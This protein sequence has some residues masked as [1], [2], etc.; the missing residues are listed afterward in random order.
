MLETFF[1]LERKLYEFQRLGMVYALNH[2]YSINGCKMGLGKTIQAIALIMRVG[3][4]ALIVCP[5][6]LRNNWKAE[7]EKFGTKCY[8]GTV[9]VVSYDEFRKGK[10]TV[11]P[12]VLIFDEAH[13]LKN[14]VTKRTKF[15]HEYVKDNPPEHLLLLTGTPIKNRV[16]EFYSLMRLCSL[17]P[18]GTSGIPLKRGFYVFANH[19]CYAQDIT[20]P[21]GKTT[22]YTGLKNKP[23]LIKYLK[24]K[25]FRASE[26]NIKLPPLLKQQILIDGKINAQL[27]RELEEDYQNN[28]ISSAKANIAGVKASF[29]AKYVYDCLDSEELPILVFSDHVDSCYIIQKQLSQIN[30]SVKT[31]V[32]T[33]AT[34]MDAR[35]EYVAAFQRGD[36]RVLICTIGSMST[37][38][39]LTATNRV[40]FNDLN[41]CP[42]D[43]EQAEKRIHRIGQSKTCFVI[44]ILAEGIDKKIIDVLNEKQ[45]VLGKV[46]DNA[47]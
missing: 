38:F 43:N 24:D 27:N 21:H 36:I 40:V 18:K 10:N 16:T 30:N 37:G 7:L 42:A 23:L 44:Q 25:Y 13:Y 28:H 22:K 33:G 17:N 46:F 15:A 26:S 9:E 35:S 19:L 14:M 2:H 1:E 6:Y 39:T 12:E 11:K 31:Q 32:V 20:T 34:P 5:A 41:W 45:K 3:K 29:T 47:D 8:T 4:D